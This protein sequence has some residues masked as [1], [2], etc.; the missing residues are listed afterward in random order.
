MSKTDSNIWERFLAGDNDAFT[1]IY[2]ENI[3]HLFAYGS[4][5]TRDRELIKDAIQDLF[6]KLYVNRKS[7]NRTT[8]V[9]LYLFGSL[10]NTLYNLFRKD[11]DTYNIYDWEDRIKE[12][13]T[14]LENLL[15]E[16]QK[17][18]MQE[19]LNWIF[20]QLSLRQREVMFYRFIE[21]FSFEEIE[22]LMGINYQSIQNLIQRSIKKIRDSKERNNK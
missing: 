17:S 20:D 5:F 15:D 16:E 9:K 18:Q 6:V 3:R 10:K 13:L 12:P 11:I 4:Q 21:E 14:P 2:D 1:H 19:D 22:A 7:I 8:N